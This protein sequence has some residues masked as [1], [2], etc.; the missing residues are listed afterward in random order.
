[1]H[2]SFRGIEKFI[3]KQVIRPFLK[4]YLKREEDAR[5][6][7]SCDA[8]L[9][10]S[11]SLFSIAI[12]IRTLKGI[13]ELGHHSLIEQHQHQLPIP[14]PSLIS[15]DAHTL[16]DKG[17]VPPHDILAAIRT[18]RSA[19]AAR[20]SALD[21]A[22]LYAAMRTALRRGDS[23]MLEVLQVNRSEIQEAIKTLQ[24][25]L[26]D[27][28]VAPAGTRGHIEPEGTTHARTQGRVQGLGLQI[29]PDA[30]PPQVLSPA[31]TTSPEAVAPQWSPA[32]TSAQ[33]ATSVATVWDPEQ[34]SVFHREFLESGLDALRRLSGPRDEEE[35][36]PP[37][38]ITRY[39]FT[40]VV[41]HSC[42]FFYIHG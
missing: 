10:D 9:T 36:L 40:E 32:P 12:Q 17:D 38:T 41:L 15:D 35:S 37:W 34:D 2:S 8:S 1:V 24:R 3:H 31:P 6:I 26:E 25:A 29:G 7:V 19:Q 33:S 16:V 5:K 20:D 39:V 4:R 28:C 14:M 21:L 23:A 13:H 22:D 42:P 27:P 30:S 18:I 11:V